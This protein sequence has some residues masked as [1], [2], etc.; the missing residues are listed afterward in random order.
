MAIKKILMPIQGSTQLPISN[1]EVLLYDDSDNVYYSTTKE[2][3]FQQ[4]EVE[5]EEF[6]K[7]CE[8]T[9]SELEQQVEE[10]KQQYNEFLATYKE[11]NAKMIS[12][13][14]KLM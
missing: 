13:I 9:I 8:A 1:K 11:T 4:Y 6:K 10:L 12:M 5:F 3:L 14:E 2:A 7:Q